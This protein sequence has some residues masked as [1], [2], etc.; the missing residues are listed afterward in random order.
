MARIIN[1]SH[2][3]RISSLLS[4][5]KGKV[6]VGG[7]SNESSLFIEP[8][9]VTDVSIGDSLLSSEIFGPILPIVTY[10]TLP[11]ARQIISEI[12]ETPLSLYIM[13]EDQ[14]EA[15]YMLQHTR[16]GGMAINDV[17]AHVAVTS[18][19]FGGFGQSG[20]GS[21]RGK[22]SIDT[23]SHLKS[24]AT[25]ATSNEFEGLLEWRYATGDREEKFKFFKA[26]LEAR[27]E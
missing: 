22:A 11:E 3:N 25:V 17:M 8:T 2:W 15:Q 21:Y 26:N 6:V 12:G 9:V 20:M 10:K 18:L 23:F 5:T 19:P 7:G 14:D 4:S 13:T 16:S 1:N 24:V 27:L